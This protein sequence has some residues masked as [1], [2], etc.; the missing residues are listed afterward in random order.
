MVTCA[1][2]WIK[3]CMVVCRD[4]SVDTAIDYGLDGPG[5]ESR[6]G[7]RFSAPVHTGPAAHTASYTMGNFFLF[8]G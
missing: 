4:S 2:S 5:I 1:V 7:L 8:R 6:W 3:Y